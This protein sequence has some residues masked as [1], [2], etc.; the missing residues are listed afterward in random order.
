[1][2]MKKQWFNKKESAAYLNVT[3]KKFEKI[4][5][6]GWI[7]EFTIFNLTRFRKRDLDYF[8]KHQRERV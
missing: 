8:I 5:C 7:K 4:K 1:M 6:R 3:S 2:N